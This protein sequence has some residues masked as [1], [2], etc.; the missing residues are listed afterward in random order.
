MSDTE[1]LAERVEHVLELPTDELTEELPA[2]LDD[3]EGQVEVLALQNP[4]LLADVID[5]VGDVDVAEFAE[6]NPDTVDQFQELQ[7][8]GVE[9]LAQF[10]PDVQQS[11]EQDTT[12]N[13]EATDAPMASHLELDADEGSV[14]GG[15]GLAD[16][17]DLEIRGPA[18]TLTALTT[19]QLDPVAGYEDDQFEMEGSEATG[20]QLATTM[21]K[22]A[23]KLPE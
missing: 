4:L 5:R 10:S 18:N 15:A 22:L 17:P 19:G 11:I 12:V 7:W 23:E 2:V 3:I 14:S 1:D 16:E 9:L 6:E 20:D 13:F 8:Q 21:G